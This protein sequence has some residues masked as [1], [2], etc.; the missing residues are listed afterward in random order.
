MT[1]KWISGAY[2]DYPEGRPYPLFPAYKKR[3]RREKTEEL[4]FVSGWTDKGHFKLPEDP[5][6]VLWSDLPDR[7]K[8][9]VC[10]GSYLDT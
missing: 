6:S 7:T 2:F 8:K 1:I 3:W 4:L 9:Y 10:E 5:I